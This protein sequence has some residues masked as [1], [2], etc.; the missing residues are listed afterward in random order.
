MSLTACQT[1]YQ[2]GFW[3]ALR[4]HGA[5]VV[6][7]ERPVKKQK[8]SDTVAVYGAMG[9][10]THLRFQHPTTQEWVQFDEEKMAAIKKI[11]LYCKLSFTVTYKPCDVCVSQTKE[12]SRA[13]RQPLD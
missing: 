10:M 3:D 5:G 8:R 2:Y 13:I 4:G 6:A 1:A 9:C 7:E 11:Y 12:G